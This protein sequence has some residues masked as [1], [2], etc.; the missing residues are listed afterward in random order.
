MRRIVFM[1]GLVSALLLGQAP[2][3]SASTSQ[4]LI[5]PLSGGQVV[6][7]PGDA[8]GDGGIYL[9]LGAKSGTLCFFAETTNVAAPL[10]A[11]H[12]HRGGSGETGDPVLQLY[13]RSPADDPDVSNCFNLDEALIKEISRNLGNYYIDIHNE[14]FP[15]GAIRGQLDAG[16]PVQGTA[17]MSGDQVVLGPGDPDG[18]AGALFGTNDE[19]RFCFYA[20]TG[21]TSGPTTTVHLHRGVTGQ[22]GEIIEI[23]HGAS[24]D[25]DVNGCVNLSPELVDDI[26]KYPERYYIDIHNQEFPDGALRGQ[27]A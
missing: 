16:V 7:A 1:V 26:G 9:T 5:F 25:P 6:P 23:L 13:G 17:D 2:G 15:D 12:L 8:D 22:V 4:A 27:L 19:G 11:V 21:N 20:D 24:P 14:E 18:G 3:A 10:T